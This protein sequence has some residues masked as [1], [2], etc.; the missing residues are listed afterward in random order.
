MKTIHKLAPHI[1]SKIAAGEVIERPAYA[2]KEL[3]ENAIDANANRIEVHIEES[4]L[5]KIT[6][7]D[8]GK[9]MSK[10]DLELCFLP[11]TTSKIKDEEE[12]MG[13]KTLG[14]RGEALSSIAAISHLTLKSRT[15]DNPAG[16]IVEIENGILE[17][18]APIGMP[19]GTIVTVEHI[20]HTIPARK[21]FLKSAQTEFRHITDVVI[22]AAL[23]FSQINFVLTH[24]NKTILDLPKKGA[25][26]DRVKVLFGESI[27][28]HLLPI[29]SEDGHII[30]SGFIG[31]P[32]VAAKQNLRQY[33]FVNNRFVTD[34]IISLAIR[35]AYGTLLPASSTP[36]FK[37]DI[38]IPYELVD[39]NVHP[40]KEQVTYVNAKS[41]FDAVK[42][43]V[44]QTLSEHNLTFNLAKFKYESSAKIGETQ[45]LSGKLLKETVLPWNREDSIQLSK[46]SPVIQI[47]S[48][49]LLALTRNGVLL[50]DQ[51]AAHERILYEQFLQTFEKKKKEHFQLS[52][53]ITLHLSVSESQILEEYRSFFLKLGFDIEHFQGSSF[54]I[55]SIPVLYK[56]RNIE[57]IIRDMIDDLLNETGLKTI[58][59]KTQRMLA[60]LSCHA[61][62]KAGDSLT[63]EQAAKLVTQIQITKNNTT[64]PHGRP[65]QIEMP[66]TML[67]KMF[68]R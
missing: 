44:S 62:V 52:K 59:S 14:F 66:I 32:Q 9:G 29:A 4:G 57:K 54:V 16:T 8:N 3:I 38:Q 42:L 50:I 20:F 13:I 33:V 2:V 27:F 58:D 31:K 47:H 37:L 1:I 21:K 30:I 17:T 10:E 41:I 56:G 51:H 45:S 7:I 19:P 15:A 48:T 22:H 24:N 49:Y 5:G 67:D 6:V 39:V 25:S 26:E 36:I 55:R 61:A 18:L 63:K 23:S 53:P 28:E 12:L 46:Q 40:R 64:C 34:K 11:H 35:E 65:T 60:F 43:A 68:K